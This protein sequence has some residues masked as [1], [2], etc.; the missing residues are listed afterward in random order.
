MKIYL[1]ILKIQNENLENKVF[2]LK[3]KPFFEF[4]KKRIKIITDLKSKQ[5]HF[6]KNENFSKNSCCGENSQ[7]FK[8]K[9]V[10]E[11]FLEKIFE[12]N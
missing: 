11:F 9:M 4:I 6:H 12:K 10:I 5:I 2:L 3:M 7:N 8:L 1:I